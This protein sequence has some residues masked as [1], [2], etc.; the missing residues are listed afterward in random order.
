MKH[1]YFYRQK[2]IKDLVLKKPSSF[3][4]LMQAPKINKIVIDTST[5]KVVANP[6]FLIACIS[7]LETICGQKPKITHA[8][9]SIANF[10]L[11]K[12]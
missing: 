10:K 9:K 6:E 7:C 12:N 4:N 5:S 11:R 3:Q 8:K 1:K 2:L